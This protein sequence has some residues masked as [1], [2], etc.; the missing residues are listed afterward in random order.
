[1]GAMRGLKTWIPVAVVLAVLLAGY[2]IS[3]NARS[4]GSSSKAKDATPAA[5]VAT[6]ASASRTA[7]AVRTA[8]VA[9]TATPLQSATPAATTNTAAWGSTTPH[10]LSVD[11]SAGGHTLDRHV[12]RTDA[13]L[14]QRLVDEPDISA[15]STYTDVAVAR[16]AVGAAL[17]K[18]QAT[19]RAWEQRTGER[20]NL[21]IRFEAPV[22]VGRSIARGATKAVET[23]DV[24]I[25][26][27]WAGKDW[28]VLTSYPEV[29]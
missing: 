15:A 4:S 24:V 13:Q 28:Y 3:A 14:R 26:L 10:N 27:R 6:Q 29:R 8:T 5:T 19:V 12:G 25:V 17:A 16:L 18:N 1:M 7:T 22:I 21:T 23:K 20:P 9:R 2:F 11:E